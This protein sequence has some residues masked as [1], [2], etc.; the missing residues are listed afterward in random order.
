MGEN[1]TRARGRLEAAGA[2]AAVDV[3]AP[4]RRLRDDRAGVGTDVDGPGPVA[5]H[6]EAAEDRKQLHRRGELMLDDRQAAA[7]RV[8]EIGVDPGADH[9]LALVRLADVD[10]DLVRHHHAVDHRLDR[11]G[12]QGLQ[13]VALDRQP[14][15]GHRREDAGVGG[16]D[17]THL[18]RADG[19]PR[20]FHPGDPVCVPE[21]RGDLAVLDDVDAAGVGGPGQPPRHRIVAGDAAA[22]L[23]GRA[24]HRIAG[25]RRA[26][27]DRAERLDLLHVQ[28]LRV[29]AVEADGVDPPLQL[30]KI[31]EGMGEIEHPA[32]AEHDVEVDVAGEPLEQPQRFLVEVGALVPQVVGA[33][34]GG[35]AP[36]VAAA[37]PSLLEDRDVGDPV[38]LGQVVGGGEAVAAAADDDHVVG[39]LRLRPPPGPRPVAVAAHR[40]PRQAE[41]RVSVHDSG[42]D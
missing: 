31:V 36:G 33:D 10:V 4:D 28:H 5:Q 1:P 40:M 32:L 21:D 41:D 7:R 27:D 42:P 25:V 8:A 24:E 11:L 17:D 6:P 19:A 18:R 15:P 2:P 3:E 12:D 13:R 37:E 20:G 23:Q 26:V 30:A 14:E 22:P 39:V 34:D 35:V 16:D 29:D 38:L 9:Q